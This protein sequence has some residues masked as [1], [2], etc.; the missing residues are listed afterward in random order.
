MDKTLSDM[1]KQLSFECDNG[2]Q[3][4]KQVLKYK[5]TL[6]E[7]EGVLVKEQQVQNSNTLTNYNSIQT[8]CK[9][10]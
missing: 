8:Y 9:A 7:L 2:Q 4:T 10:P 5:T 3:L 1:K 6:L